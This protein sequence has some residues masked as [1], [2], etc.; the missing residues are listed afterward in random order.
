MDN[1]Q[2]E[3]WWQCGKENFRTDTNF[4]RSGERR[5][6][7]P[8]PSPLPHSQLWTAGDLVE[9]RL[10][11]LQKKI[12]MTFAK[13]CMRF[14]HLMAVCRRLGQ[15][16]NHNTDAY[17]RLRDLEELRAHLGCRIHDSDMMN[18]FAKNQLARMEAALVGAIKQKKDQTLLS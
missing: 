17:H 8:E 3:Y 13:D 18:D 9:D 12:I 14:G 7:F 5:E 1:E 6:H 4:E 11:S 2:F 15:K 16:I 10:F